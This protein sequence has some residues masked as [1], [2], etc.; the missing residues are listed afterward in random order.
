MQ[1]ELLLIPI[2][3]IV[4]IAF[5]ASIIIILR[6]TLGIGSREAWYEQAYDRLDKSVNRGA[7]RFFRAIYS[8]VSIPVKATVRL[9]VVLGKV[10]LPLAVLWFIIS[11]I[12]WAWHNPLF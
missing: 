12:R 11:A 4:V 7:V 9:V 10:A 3:L 2:A 5:W 6:R 1:P 8:L